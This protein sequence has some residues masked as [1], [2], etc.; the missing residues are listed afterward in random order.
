MELIAKTQ[1]VQLESDEFWRTQILP[2]LLK[3][4]VHKI[5]AKVSGSVRK[6]TGTVQMVGETYPDCDIYFYDSCWVVLLG[7]A[8]PDPAKREPHYQEDPNLGS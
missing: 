2:S 1:P 5:E 8:D 6:I 7:Y 3:R 4:I